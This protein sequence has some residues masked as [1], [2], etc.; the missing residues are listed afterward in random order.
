MLSDHVWTQ[1]TANGTLMDEWNINKMEALVRKALTV[2][3][4]EREG[5]MH[6]PSLHHQ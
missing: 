5:D 3:F 6:A 2:Y 4:D 1:Y